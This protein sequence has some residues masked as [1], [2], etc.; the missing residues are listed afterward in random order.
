M[1][2][3]KTKSRTVS[4]APQIPKP[5]L[6][7][8]SK[9]LRG[10]SFRVGKKATVIVKGKIVEESLRDWEAKNRKSFKLE[11]NKITVPKK[12]KR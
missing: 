3:K 11:I 4:E 9:R 8:D 7:I 1:P 10:N 6:L 5:T 2:K 12:K